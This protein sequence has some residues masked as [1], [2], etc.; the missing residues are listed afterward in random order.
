MISR[1]KDFLDWKAKRKTK[2]NS[3][4][5]RKIEENKEPFTRSRET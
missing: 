1:S 5:L 2:H 4:T 3:E